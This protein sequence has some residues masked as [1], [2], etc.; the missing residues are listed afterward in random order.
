[1]SRKRVETS[2]KFV[3]TVLIA[4]D[5]K[6]LVRALGKS[7]EDEGFR[8][9]TTDSVDGSVKYLL[10]K[11]FDVVI[12]DVRMPEQSGNLPEEDAGIVIGRLIQ[13]LALVGRQTAVVL[14]T[15]YPTVRDM[16]TAVNAGVYYL[17]KTLLGDQAGPELVQQCKRLVEQKCMRQEVKRAWVDQHFAE[18]VKRFG[19]KTVAVTDPKL[20]TGIAVQGGTTIGDR[21]VFTAKTR[22]EL[23]GMIARNPKLRRAA[24]VLLSIPKEKEGL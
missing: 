12:L 4:D 11:S 24:P 9:S 17:P 22:E 19:G 14:F 5:E 10:E 18:L 1:M 16:F 13:R 7:F 20:A 2:K 8:V 3:P 21:K 6:A 15:A 23:R